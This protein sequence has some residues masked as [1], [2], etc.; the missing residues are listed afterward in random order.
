MPHRMVPWL[1]GQRDE[2]TLLL[3]EIAKDDFSTPGG[4]PEHHDG[5]SLG[6]RRLPDSIRAL[7]NDT[8]LLLVCYKSLEPHSKH[9]D[10]HSSRHT[11]HADHPSRRRRRRQ[12]SRALFTVG[13][14]NTTHFLDVPSRLLLTAT[15]PVTGGGV[16]IDVRARG[17][18]D[19]GE[20]TRLLHAGASNGTPRRLQLLCDWAVLDSATWNSVMAEAL[21]QDLMALT[22]TAEVAAAIE[23]LWPFVII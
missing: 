3:R 16:A 2:V 13:G 9:R 18:L 14:R 20:P 15:A 4:I 1:D 19:G 17:F 22:P 5:I 12:M 10:T 7:R 11:L 23:A 8:S 21:Q 6:D